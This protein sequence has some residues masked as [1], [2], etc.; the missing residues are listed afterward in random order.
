MCR[1]F[2]RTHG[3]LEASNRIKQQAPTIDEYDAFTAA[4]RTYAAKLRNK[5]DDGEWQADRYL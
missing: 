5:I 3:K 1:L 2:Q 4:A